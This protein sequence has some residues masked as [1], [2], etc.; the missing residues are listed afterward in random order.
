MPTSSQSRPKILAVSP[1]TG[2]PSL[3]WPKRLIA[4][5]AS[6]PSC[7]GGEHGVISQSIAICEEG[8]DI[9]SILHLP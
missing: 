4:L 5:V 2:S 1:M 8:W 9:Q 6:I 3:V 7:E